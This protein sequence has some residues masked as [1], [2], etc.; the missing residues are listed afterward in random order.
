MQPARYVI[1]GKWRCASNVDNS[2]WAVSV[3]TR[4]RNRRGHA[5]AEELSHS[6]IQALF[7]C[8][9]GSSLELAY[10]RSMMKLRALSSKP[11]G[12]RFA[13][14]VKTR[15]SGEVQKYPS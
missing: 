4:I 13:S 2:Q 12:A 15:D 3:E 10:K 8:G 7:S 1:Q 14:A 5:Y 6:A 11:W 9:G